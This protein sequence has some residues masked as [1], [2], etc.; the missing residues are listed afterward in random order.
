M[1]K[2][3]LPNPINLVTINVW[4][5]MD[6]RGVYKI[7]DYEN[8]ARKNA[9]FTALISSLKEINPDVVAIQEANQL[10]GYARK[11]ARTLDYDAVWKVQ[12]SGVK[13][14][15]FGIP[16]NFTAGNVILAKKDHFLKYLSSHRLSGRGIQFN[17]FSVHFKEMRNAMAAMVE[18]DGHPILFFNT[19]THFSL[20]LQEKWERTVDSMF[21]RRQ[22]TAHE[23]KAI[24]KHMRA[25]HNRT[26]QDIFKMLE[27]IKQITQKYDYPYVVMGDFNTTLKSEAMASMVSELGLLDPFRIKNPDVNGYTW[28]PQRNTNTAFDSSYFWAD[29]KTPRNPLK[30]LTAEFD[31]NTPR[32]IDFIFLSKHFSA[33]MIQQ[34]N[35]I[36]DAPVDNLF[37]S[38]HFG[39]QVVLKELPSHKK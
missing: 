5:G 27:F 11:I 4:F 23:K 34:A 38:D 24:K 21:D 36:F 16:V 32:R 33:D 18:I 3:M 25:S 8:Q 12:N 14:M 29:G 19:Q 39:I 7:G 13:I 20:I 22:I 17:C 31:A 37:I 26:E 15:G 9:R 2:K 30:R 6:G 1:A 28:D 35:L 10:P